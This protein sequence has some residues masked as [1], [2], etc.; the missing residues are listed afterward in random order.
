MLWVAADIDYLASNSA[1]KQNTMVNAVYGDC[2]VD[3]I[4]DVACFQ[5]P[6][7]IGSAIKMPVGSS[8]FSIYGIVVVLS[9]TSSHAAT[10]IIHKV[11]LSDDFHFV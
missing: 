8:Y 4:A 10:R 5:H 2:I 1:G 7:A 3:D 9:T 6:F 11:P